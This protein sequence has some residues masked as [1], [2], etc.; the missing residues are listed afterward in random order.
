MTLK[1]VWLL[2][3]ASIP[4]YGGIFFFIFSTNTHIPESTFKNMESTI[5]YVLLFCA[6]SFGGIVL[7]LWDRHLKDP[8]GHKRTQLRLNPSLSFKELAEEQWSTY[9]L[10]S[11]ISYALT[12]TISIYGLLLSFMTYEFKYFIWF[13]I[14]ASL[15]FLLIYPKYNKKN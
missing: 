5:F 2:M 6:L 10:Y 3:F 13:S 11:I 14:P 15:I 4:I 12:E 7:F 9:F 8:L 1:L